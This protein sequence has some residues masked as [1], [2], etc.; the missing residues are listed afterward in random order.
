VQRSLRWIG[1]SA[2]IALSGCGWLPGRGD[3]TK[4]YLTP[5][6]Y[7]GARAE[8]GP[9]ALDAVYLNDSTNGIEG[10][11]RLT[12]WNVFSVAV[13]NRSHAEVRIAPSQFAL[14][15][16]RNQ[17]QTALSLD[18]VLG[19]QSHV[20]GPLM[21]YQRRAIRRAF[22]SNEPIAPG[23][24]AVGYVF[25]PRSGTQLRSFRLVLDPDPARK[26]D[27][28]V[29]L[30]SLPGES[31]GGQAPVVSLP[32]D[33]ARTSSSPPAGAQTLQEAVPDSPLVAQPSGPPASEPAPSA[34][35]SSPNGSTDPPSPG[36]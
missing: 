18:A 19:Y 3:K 34:D 9:T 24:F 7:Y 6:G 11:V 29:A 8:R 4:T 15:D 26:K 5:E 27:E 16:D 13:Q 12:W 36:P 14:V 30:F 17:Q 28:I 20:T 2:L 22:W 35:T 32:T 33:T 10:M 23:A 1:L 25:F 21:S 31:D